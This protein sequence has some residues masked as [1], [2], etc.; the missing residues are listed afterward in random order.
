MSGAADSGGITVGN[1]GR[2][3][4]ER[5]RPSPV[6]VGAG[7]LCVLLIVYFAASTDRFLTAGNAGVVATQVAVLGLVTLGQ[8][9]VLLAGG[10]DISISGV[11]PLSAVIFVSLANTGMSTFLVC[12]VVLV[13]GAL[14]GTVNG[15]IVTKL[16][17]NP[18]IATL[19]TM[20]ICQGFAFV[21]TDGNTVPLESAGAGFLADSTPFG[22]P[23]FVLVFIGIAAALFVYLKWTIPGRALYAVGGGP[24]A[25][26][27]AGMR[28]DLTKTS[29]FAISATLAALAGIVLSSQLLAGSPSIGA[30]MTLTS[31]TAA[32]LGGASLHG[33]IGGVPGTLLGIV[34]IGT[35]R[36]GLALL[37]VS[38]FYQLVATGF[39]LLIAVSMA[40]MKLPGRRKKSERPPRVERTAV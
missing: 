34:I 38:A 2:A 19:G 35:L 31:I 11:V 10:F 17:V 13:A 5:A 23:V 20:S 16:K 3:L 18:L 26:R 37:E 7:T 9:I 24:E 29:A 28:A 8:M 27:L 33:G 32:V 12:V 36:N 22:V 40:Q 15:L 25:A 39:V 30:D 21:V 1:L 6:M 14:I 4:A